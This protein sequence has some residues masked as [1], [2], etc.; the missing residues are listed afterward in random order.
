M[1]AAARL[2]LTDEDLPGLFEAAD[3]AS[4]LGQRRYLGMTRWR[5]WLAIVAAAFGVF[6]V[7]VGVVDLAAIATALA[8]VGVVLI[9][10]GL[11]TEKP[12]ERRYDGRALAE[13]AKSLAWR[14]SVGAAPFPRSG[15]EKATEQQFADQ[16]RRLLS[17]APDTGI[18]ASG[19]GG[20]TEG[21]RRLRAA[22]LAA[23]RS[24][25][26]EHRVDDQRAWY[27]RKS[28]E[29]ER[30]SRKW[31]TGL[32]VIE[33]AGIAAAVARA[34]GFVQLDLAGVVAALIAA[35]A[36]WSGMRQLDK[37]ARAYA[38]A[39][40]DLA[41]VRD[42]LASATGESDWPPRPRTRRRP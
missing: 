13:S 22:D 20:V 36:A 14:F 5:L 7:K 40:N 24:S 27:M 33:G 4:V 23:R 42:R 8:L 34:V 30:Q 1:T 26:L 3:S 41:I 12:E 19:R 9:E 31:Q 16:L 17:D 32:F 28:D 29:N 38:F 10:I 21:M 37:L 18:R 2:R 11:R 6:P 15:N 35:G 25:Y 39:A